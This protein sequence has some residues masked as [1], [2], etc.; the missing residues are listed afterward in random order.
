MSKKLNEDVRTKLKLDVPL[1]VSKDILLPKT[2]AELIFTGLERGG[3]Q[4][5]ERVNVFNLTWTTEFHTIFTQIINPFLQSIHSY[6][7]S[8]QLFCKAKW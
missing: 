5:K 4:F 3:C 8:L 1:A 2:H 7:N 6:L